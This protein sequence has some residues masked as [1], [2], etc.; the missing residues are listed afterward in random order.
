M[1]VGGGEAEKIKALPFQESR[2]SASTQIW[3]ILERETDPNFLFKILEF[4]FQ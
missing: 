4:I 1:G 3:V 2:Y